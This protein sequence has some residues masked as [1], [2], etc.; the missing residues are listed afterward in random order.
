M[1]IDAGVQRRHGVGRDPK[2]IIGQVVEYAKWG[3]YAPAELKLAWW[4]SAPR[5]EELLNMDY[6]LFVRMRAA[7]NIHR[8]VTKFRAFT[9]QR[10]HTLSDSERRLLRSLIDDGF[11]LLGK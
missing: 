6:S 9:D 4:S 2:R 1:G 8:T 7:D 3:G 10:I 5:L 11:T